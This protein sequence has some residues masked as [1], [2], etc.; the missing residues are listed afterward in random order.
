MFHVHVHADIFNA[1]HKR[2]FLSDK[3]GREIGE[4]EA[5]TNFG[6]NRV[7]GLDPTPKIGEVSTRF[8][9]WLTR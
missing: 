4:V 6:D 7:T 1:G 3:S 8:S 5:S 9:V 2:V